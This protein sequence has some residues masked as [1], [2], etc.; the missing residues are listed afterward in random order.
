MTP[1]DK[2]M[3]GKQLTLW[4]IV[5]LVFM[6]MQFVLTMTG[7]QTLDRDILTIQAAAERACPAPESVYNPMLSP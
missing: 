1:P 2:N 3:T 4:A 7:H 6:V 5:L